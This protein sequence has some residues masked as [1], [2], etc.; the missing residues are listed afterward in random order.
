MK[1]LFLDTNVVIDFLADRKP[2]SINA[3]RIFEAGIAKKVKLFISVVSYNNIY[4][5]IRQSLTHV[6][7][8]KLLQDLC[9]MT[10]VADVTKTVITSSLKSNFN[11]FEDAIQYHCALAVSN[12]DLIITRNSK[13]FR[14]SRVP[15]ISPEE[16]LSLLSL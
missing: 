7:T 6:Q 2:F 14:K 16:V 1:T 10:E 8:I 13:D 15:V 5:I 4:Y 9:E 11:D 3:A 12:I